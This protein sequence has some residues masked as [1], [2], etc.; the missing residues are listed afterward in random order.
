[1]KKL[2]MAAVALICMTVTSVALIACGGDGPPRSF[3]TSLAVYRCLKPCP[4][5]H[6]FSSWKC[7]CR[8]KNNAGQ[9]QCVGGSY[10]VSERLMVTLG[11]NSLSTYSF[12]FSKGILIPP[13]SMIAGYSFDFLAKVA[14]KGM[15]FSSAS[16]RMAPLTISVQ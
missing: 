10:W 11:R 7:P 1:M 14:L 15:P 5:L 4:F 8:M 16:K 9:R 6:V 13:F 3:L 2:L 12:C